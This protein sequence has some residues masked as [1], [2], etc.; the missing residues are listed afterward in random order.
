MVE[1]NFMVNSIKHD[2]EENSFVAG[3]LSVVIRFHSE[4]CVEH[5][6][7]AVFSLAQQNIN[8]LEIVVAVKNPTDKLI[9]DIEE[10]VRE[11]PWLY[12]PAVQICHASMDEKIDARVILLN[13]GISAATGQYLSFLDFDD[14]IYP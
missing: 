2:L 8:D 1:T 11:Q 12:K 6:E 10:M 4:G 13:K 3:R 5:L 9:S 14:A 7:Q